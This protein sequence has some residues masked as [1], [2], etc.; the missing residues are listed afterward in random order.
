M[1]TEKELV[2]LLKDYQGQLTHNMNFTQEQKSKIKIRAIDALSNSI[3]KLSMFLNSQ[4]TKESII[5]K[6]AFKAKQIQENIL[7]SLIKNEQ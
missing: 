6:E 7:K 3:E 1:K 5:T 4:E 2:Q